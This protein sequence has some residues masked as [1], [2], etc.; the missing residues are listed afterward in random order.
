MI[1][2]IQRS[3][4]SMSKNDNPNDEKY[5]LY[6]EERKILIEA[7]REG[8]R[9]FDKAILTLASGSFGFSIAFI[10]DIV[11]NPL[12]NTLWLLGCS[13][14][15]FSLSIIIIL[16]SFIFSQNACK[17]QIDLSYEEIMSEIITRNIWST[18]TR[19]SNYSS[20]ILIAAALFFLGGFVYWNLIYPN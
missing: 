9:T 14:V 10:K 6:L 17:A 4:A 2:F 20:I 1:D 19:I 15:L 8:S 7:L 13:W 18:I 3:V 5:E 11:P 12:S 16:L